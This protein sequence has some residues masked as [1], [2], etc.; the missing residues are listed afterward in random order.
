MIGDAYGQMG[1]DEID[2]A[3]AM[4]A[5]AFEINQ[6]SAPIHQLDAVKTLRGMG[7]V[8]CKVGERTDEATKY[9]QEALKLLKRLY[10]TVYG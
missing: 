2:L 1:S 7:D 6:H 4:Y 3:L 8:C 9:Y 10:T 5:C